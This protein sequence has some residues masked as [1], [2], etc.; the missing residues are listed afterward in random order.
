MSVV[1]F[2]L[3]LSGS[4]C[5]D[6]EPAGIFASHMVLQ[7]DMEIPVWGT[8]DPGE[9]VTVS[10]NDQVQSITADDQG[11]WMLTLDPLKTG[12]ALTMTIKGDN[13][14]IFDDILVGE[15]WLCSG[16]SNMARKVSSVINAQQEIDSANHPQIRLNSQSG[17]QQCS[18]QTVKGFSATGYFFGRELYENLKVPVG[19][20]NRS[21]GG[22][23][24]EK[25]TPKEAVLNTPYG[26]EMFE[27]SNSKATQQ[28]YRQYMEAARKT[29]ENST[30]KRGK[31][32][33]LFAVGIYSEE[34]GSLY[35][36]HIQ[37]VIPFAIRGV[38]W[39]QG[40]RN[41]KCPGGPYAYRQLLPAMIKAWRHEWRQGDFPFYFVQLPNW[42][43]GKNWPLLRES[44]LRSMN[45]RN[46][47][48]AVTIDIGGSLH[49][50]NK[51]DVGK[52]LALWALAKTYDKD[53]TPSG[54]LYRSY[55]I[56]AGKIIISFD[57]TDGGLVAKDGGILKG[58]TI[59]GPCRDFLPADAVIKG[60][61]VLVSSDKI[62]N[63]VAVR[64][65]WE[66]DPECNLYN[67][68]LLPASPF[69]SD[70]WPIEEE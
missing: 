24:I 34:L 1:V 27:I 18:P 48:M 39:Y 32:R 68:A 17:W 28:R 35:K 64:Y 60:N 37:P 2:I 65:A 9:K 49:P 69:R 31:S 67:K 47:G 45:T 14:I 8:T 41:A 25:W 66:K 44:M 54:P 3:I 36:A 56:E 13:T 62:K 20:I 61:K 70:N 10:I 50:K 38:I 46:T 52:R 29:K 19:L 15:V 12:K 16:Q 6:V 40:E 11:K 21:Q 51:Q 23:P 59:A 33:V 30:K 57:Y 43:G 42:A 7:R 4:S 55:E 5:A 26:R 63:P 22:T 58:F 53:V